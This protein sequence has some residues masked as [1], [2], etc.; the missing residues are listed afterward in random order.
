MNRRQMVAL[1]GLAVIASQAL[2][3]TSSSSVTTALSHKAIA[4]FGRTK[5]AYSVPKSEGKRTK[6][7][8]FLSALLTLTSA[9]ASQANEIF[10]SAATAT[11]TVRQQMK[12]SRQ[13][14]KAAVTGLDS[15]SIAAR[16]QEIGQLTM[17]LH[18]VGG[19]AHAALMQLLTANQQATLTQFTSSPATAA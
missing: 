19:N 9:Q 6:Y 2:S 14:L 7:I 16:A 12:I 15:T 11:F 1:P 13:A 10:A 5:S 3:Q 4:K 18:L 17:K 8:N